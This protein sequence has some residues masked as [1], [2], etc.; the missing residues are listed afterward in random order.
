MAQNPFTSSESSRY[1]VLSDD[2]VKSLYPKTQQPAATPAPI[3]SAG[4]TAGT[5]SRAALRDFAIRRAQELDIDPALATSIL[6]Q[7]SG[8]NPNVGNSPKGARGPGQVM[9]DTYKMMMGTDAGQDDPFNSVEAGLRYLKYGQDK[10]GTRD[11]LILASGY[12]SGMDRPELRRGELPDTSDGLIKTADYARSVA[13]RMGVRSPESRKNAPVD[14]LAELNKEEPGRYEVVQPEADPLAELN[15]SEPGRYEVLPEAEAIKFKTDSTPQDGSGNLL[16]DIGKGLKV[17]L[18]TAALDL[19]EG[20]RRI[21]GVGESIVSGL[22]KV[23]NYFHP[24]FQT[25]EQLLKADTENMTK[26]MTPAM[27]AALQKKWWDEKTDS[28]GDAWKDPRAYIGGVVQSLPEQALTMVPAMRLAKFAYGA[29]VAAGATEAAAAVAAARTATVAGGVAEGLLGGAQSAREVRDKVMELPPE[30][31]AQSE[32]F[33][34]LLKSGMTPADAQKQLAED[35]ATRAFITSGVATGMFGGMGDRMIAKIMLEKV[36]GSAVKRVLRDAAKGTIAEGLFEELPQSV[37]QQVSQNEAIQQANPN[38]KLGEDVINQGLGGAVLGGLQGGGMAGVAGARAKPA[39]AQPAAAPGPQPAAPAAAAP[40][41]PINPVKNAPSTA[42]GPL[43]RATENAANTPDR[44][45]ATAAD[46]AKVSGTVL[47]TSDDGKVQ[48]VS[49]D[50]EIVTMRT[51]PGGVKIEIE[52]PNTP[53]TNALEAAA[54][55]HAENPAPAVEATAEQPQEAAPAAEPVAEAPAAEPAPAPKPVQTVAEMD[56]PA[57]RERQKYIADQARSAGGWTAMF[58]K[59]RREVEKELQARGLPIKPAAEPVVEPPAAATP[60]AEPEKPATL[61]ADLKGAKPRY[62]YGKKQF[63][64]NFASDLDRAAY[65]AAQDTPSKRD[66]DYL[67]FATESTGMT[68]DEVRAHGR[69]VRDAIKSQAKDASPGVLKVP[70][71]SRATDV[72]DTQSPARPSPQPEAPRPEE[73]APARADGAEPAAGVPDAGAAAQP[74]EAAGLTEALKPGGWTQLGDESWERGGHNGMKAYRRED[75]RVIVDAYEQG[76]PTTIG[77][78]DP[79]G[80]S[81]KQIADEVARIVAEDEAANPPPAAAPDKPKKLPFVSKEDGEHLFGVPEKR[82][83]AMERIAAGK[84]WFNDGVKAKDFITKNGLSDTHE[85]KQGKGG[86]FDIVAKATPQEQTNGNDQRPDRQPD[87]AQEV[88]RRQEAE[89]AAQPAAAVQP[90]AAPAEEVAA[91]SATDRYNE[92]VPR[93]NDLSARYKAAD[94]QGKAAL[95]S[96]MDKLDAEMRAARGQSLL[97]AKRTIEEAGAAR[98]KQEAQRFADMPIGARLRPSEHA[99]DKGLFWEKTG[100]DEWTGRGDWF[101]NGKTRT[102]AEQAERGGLVE[103]APA[104]SPLAQIFTGLESRGQA[105][106]DAEQALASH[107]EAAKLQFVEDHF[108]ALLSDL[109]ESNRVSIEC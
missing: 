99:E 29:K 57:L 106:K 13:A 53:L 31:L 91:P 23:D 69:K 70:E 25:S 7:E 17:G 22:D 78:V 18:N 100:P 61:P 94:E 84:A 97:D 49:D 20:I 6:I 35:T 33:Q 58:I 80:K 32:A 65:I 74:V 105:K 66:A 79:K 60:V 10:I 76:R 109:E 1:E 73:A 2:E 77:E 42:A 4:A 47:G 44:V 39:P 56:E 88:E 14:P 92:M 45:T 59:A 50:G 26:G 83:K 46:G 93:W 95:K 12:H 9:P 51:G 15:A 108:W 36:G 62:S 90:D 64:I 8:G 103:M 19:R 67:R 54:A 85:V 101:Q 40:E 27:Q 86:R 11:P 82:K 3:R 89:P 41:A 48:I 87:G 96:E 16:T 71:L 28:F 63:E 68:E 98:A 21:P 102:S 107:P 24:E 34:T 38:Q 55:T 30:V 104:A 37:L 43:S 75:G 52:A 72:Q 81:P 5:V